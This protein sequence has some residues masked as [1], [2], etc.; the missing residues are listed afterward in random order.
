MARRADGTEGVAGTAGENGIDGVE[1][2]ARG[3]QGDVPGA[4]A[5]VGI[6]GAQVWAAGGDIA[7]S[8]GE[9]FAG[10]AKEKLVSGGGARLDEW[11]VERREGFHHR[12]E[13]LGTLGLA[14]AA[15]EV[16][17]ADGVGGKNGAKRHF[18]HSFY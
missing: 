14:V 2:A 4:R 17:A 8:D 7:V 13:A 5:D 18:S 6:A 11:E 15:R 1:G 16:L 3:A 12:V 10:V 9:V